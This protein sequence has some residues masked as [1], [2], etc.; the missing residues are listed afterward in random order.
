MILLRLLVALAFLPVRLLVGLMGLV[1]VPIALWR[2]DRT[3]RWPKV[4]DTWHNFRDPVWNLPK[5]YTDRYAP[6]HWLGKH[7]PRVY[8]FAIRNPANNMR[9]W[10]KEP[11]DFS[12]RGWVGP[13]EPGTARAAGFT[14]WRYRYSGLLSEFWVIHPWN[15]K[16]HFRFRLGW[17]LGQKDGD[18]DALGYAIQLM[19]VRRG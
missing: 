16:R 5:W 6:R 9:L 14:L 1:L 4:L 15:E 18:T 7:F 13:M 19:P 3:G 8:W 10:F 2:Y 11:E 17:K 12:Q